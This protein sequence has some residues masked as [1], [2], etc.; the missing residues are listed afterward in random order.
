MAN[1]ITATLPEQ[2]QNVQGTTAILQ[3]NIPASQGIGYLPNSDIAFYPFGLGTSPVSVVPSTEVWRLIDVVIYSSITP[4][5]I[6][7]LVVNGQNQ[8]FAVDLNTV[9]VSGS[10]SRVHPINPYLDIPANSTFNFT[11]Y[12]TQANGTSAQTIN[13]SVIMQRI[14]L[15][16]YLASQGATGVGASHVLSL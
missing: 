15:A 8:P 10:S 5:I 13:V 3:L 9:V 7:G 12:L 4:D 11:A 6:L 16:V 1:V 14:P 2:I